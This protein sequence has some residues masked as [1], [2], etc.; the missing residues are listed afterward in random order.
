MARTL[1]KSTARA[2]H[3]TIAKPGETK[4][5][6]RADSAPDHLDLPFFPDHDHSRPYKKSDST[7]PSFLYGNPLFDFKRLRGIGQELRS[8]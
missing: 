8:D 5:L 1:K 2:S 4:E 7:A 6:Y 3:E